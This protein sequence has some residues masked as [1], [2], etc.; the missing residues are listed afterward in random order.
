M[1]GLSKISSKQ[2]PFIIDSPLGRLDG[3]HVDN[4]L[5]KFFPNAGEQVIILPHD[6]EINKKDYDKIKSSVNKSYLI[7]KSNIKDKI[8]EG[9]F[10]EV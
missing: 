5:T 1:W 9:Y 2:L 4:I 8:Q 7:S 10:F 6:R 3:T